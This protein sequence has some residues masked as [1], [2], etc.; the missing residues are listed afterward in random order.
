M[1]LDVSPLVTEFIFVEIARQLAKE[2]IQSA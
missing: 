1:R 2:L